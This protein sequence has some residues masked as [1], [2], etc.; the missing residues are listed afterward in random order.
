MID[1]CLSNKNKSVTVFFFQKKLELNKTLAI[2]PIF[3]IFY[4]IESFDTY[5]KY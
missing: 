3:K 1:Q 5:I 2:F 4:H